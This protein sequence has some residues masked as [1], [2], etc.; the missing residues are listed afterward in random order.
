MCSPWGGDGVCVRSYVRL[1]LLNLEVDRQKTSP[2]NPPVSASQVLWLQ[3]LAWSSL[4]FCMGA[5]S[6]NS[7]P[8]LAEQ[9]STLT[10]S[11]IVPAH[12]Q[13]KIVK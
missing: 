10:L 11:T 8:V 4:A 7:G 12:H 6:L 2:S 5:K 13:Y 1:L 3:V 9:A